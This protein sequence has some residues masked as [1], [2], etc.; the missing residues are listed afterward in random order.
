MGKA[1]DNL[2]GSEELTELYELA[3]EL[4]DI[5]RDKIDLLQLRDE[6]W[7]MLDYDEEE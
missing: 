2:F 4:T 6:Y 5:D 7:G 3:V 1:M